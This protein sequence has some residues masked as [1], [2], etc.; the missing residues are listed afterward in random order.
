MPW[1]DTNR[2]Y[3]ETLIDTGR[4]EEAYNCL[5]A[6]IDEKGKDYWAENMLALV[7]AKLKRKK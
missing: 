7:E 4:Y 1:E 2:S 5:L 3:I 6:Y